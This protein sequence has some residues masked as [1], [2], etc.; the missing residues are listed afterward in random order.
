[1]V[2]TIDFDFVKDEAYGETFYLAYGDTQGCQQ[3]EKKKMEI[4]V[5]DRVIK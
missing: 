1:M 4:V 3:K 5:M 2:D